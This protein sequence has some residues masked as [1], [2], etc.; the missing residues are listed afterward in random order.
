MNK[1]IAFI[2]IYV[3]GSEYVKESADMNRIYALREFYINPRH[4]VG[5]R[6]NKSL[7]DLFDSQ[8]IKIEGLNEDLSFCKVILNTGSN[9]TLNV[10]VVGT[11]ELIMKKIQEC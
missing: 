5:V 9:I 11:P 1:L 3:A 8:Q 10:D 6:E 7:K 2:E 4:I